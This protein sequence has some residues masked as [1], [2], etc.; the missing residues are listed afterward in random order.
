MGRTMHPLR[1]QRWFFS[2]WNPLMWPVRAM[3]PAVRENRKQAAGD[4]AF[5]KLEGVCSS[6]ITAP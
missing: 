5:R 2:D 3:A 4:N 1:A 6:M